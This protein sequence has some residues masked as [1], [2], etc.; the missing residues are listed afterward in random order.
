MRPAKRELDHL[1]EFRDRLR[2][3]DVIRGPRSGRVARA[4][5]ECGRSR[6]ARAVCGFRVDVDDARVRARIERARE[7]R[8]VETERLRV[9]VDVRALEAVLILLMRVERVV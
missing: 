5:Q 3:A 4:D 6:D 2:A 9:T 8:H 1:F 7:L